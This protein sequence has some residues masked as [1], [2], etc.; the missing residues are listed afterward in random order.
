M[1]FL[2]NDKWLLVEQVKFEKKIREKLD[3]EKLLILYGDKSKKNKEQQLKAVVKRFPKNKIYY[4][5]YARNLQYKM[6]GAHREDLPV[7]FSEYYSIME[8]LNNY[9]IFQILKKNNSNLAFKEKIQTEIKTPS[10]FL[11]KELNNGEKLEPENALYN[12]LKAYVYFSEAV[13]FTEAQPLNLILKKKHLS[14][15]EYESELQKLFEKGFFLDYLRPTKSQAIIINKEKFDLSMMEYYA[16]LKKPYLKSYNYELCVQKRLIKFDKINNFQVFCLSLVEREYDS[17]CE[18]KVYEIAKLISSYARTMFKEN[19]HRDAEELLKTLKTLLSQSAQNIQAY[20]DF[21][22]A[23]AIAEIYTMDLCELYHETGEQ[24]QLQ[25]MMK[26]LFSIKTLKDVEEDEYK[27]SITEE[28][29]GPL[30]A[31]MLSPSEYY[32]TAEDLRKKLTPERMMW[33]KYLEEFFVTFLSLIA[34]IVGLLLWGVSVLVKKR[35]F[36]DDKALFQNNL[37]VVKLSTLQWF[38][39]ILSSVIIPVAIY[40]VLT[41]FEVLSG[42]NFAVINAPVVLMQLFLLT[43]FVLLNSLIC[44]NLI[45][46]SYCQKNNLSREKLF[47]KSMI[48]YGVI[49]VALITLSTVYCYDSYRTR[50]T[51]MDGVF[52]VATVIAV[53]GVLLIGNVLIFF[54]LSF[55]KKSIKK[56]ILFLNVAPYFMIATLIICSSLSIIFERQKN[57]YFLKDELIFSKNLQKPFAELT[58]QAVRRGKKVIQEYLLQD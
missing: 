29:A 10:P 40:L 14:R 13:S 51:Y 4:A 31:I 22:F 46:K 2:D 56:L 7:I 55:F 26:H 25:K 28:S 23:R 48:C 54:T 37:V 30:S 45:V 50:L 47:S 5:N 36:S 43:I 21:A 38:F 15:K 52:A 57:Y 17:S 18:E 3:S 19:F 11:I 20:S 44:F 12:Y 42:R 53:L 9:K 35:Y 27:L 58:N 24:D 41:H 33:Y 34:F 32:N 1:G 6:F 39:F 8:K 16:G 49:M